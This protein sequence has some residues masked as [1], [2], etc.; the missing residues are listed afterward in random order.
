[1]AVVEV[2]EVGDN[3]VHVTCGAAKRRMHCAKYGALVTLQA[4]AIK[5][6]HML[7]RELG[8]LSQWPVYTNI[9]LPDSDN[10]RH[11]SR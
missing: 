10:T 3:S 4:G 6:I 7:S 2:M 1:M 9:S 11:L 5:V 8:A